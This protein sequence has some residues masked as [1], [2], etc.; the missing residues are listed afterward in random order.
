MLVERTDASAPAGDLPTVLSMVRWVS[1]WLVMLGHLRAFL[2]LD[3]G[4]LQGAGVIT[5]AFYFATGLGHQAV[6]VFFVLS[7]Y[8]V[9]GSVLSGLRKGSFSWG[10][11]AQSRLT[12]LW[13]VLIPALL[14]T[15]AVDQMGK[16]W[17]PDAYAGAL[18]ERFMSGPRWCR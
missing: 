15:L 5:K 12:R 6:M 3:F 7:G 8:F 14:L 16:G 10:R 13:M 2:F 1:A 4:E 11:Y 9:G 17:N 18:S